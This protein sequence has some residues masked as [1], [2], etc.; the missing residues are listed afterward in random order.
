MQVS[1]SHMSMG[2]FWGR[3]LFLP[4]A[5]VTMALAL[6][7]FGCSGPAASGY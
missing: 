1:H 7:A 3:S 6:V 4:R 2:H 5:R